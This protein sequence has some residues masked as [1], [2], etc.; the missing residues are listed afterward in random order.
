M[1]FRRPTPRST[2]AFGNCPELKTVKYTGS[3][4]DR[5]KIT[6]GSGNEDLT[7]ANWKFNVNY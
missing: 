4:T 3:S 7:S 5:G 1:L 2:Q 6:I